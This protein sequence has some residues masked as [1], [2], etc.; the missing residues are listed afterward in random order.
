MRLAWM[1]LL[2]SATA[3][4]ERVV[5]QRGETLEHVAA[6]HGCTTEAVEHAN[7]VDTSLVKFG[8]VVEVPNCGRITTRAR[9][10]ERV[11][12]DDDDDDAKAKHALAVIDG[13]AWVPPP[14]VSPAEAG[15]APWAGS[16]ANASKLEAGDGYIVKRPARSFGTKHLLDHLRG[17]IAEVRAL[18]PNVPTLAIGDISAEYGGKISDHR[19]HQS[20]LDVDVGFYFT[21]G[22]VKTFA[23]AGSTFDLEAN[24]A[25]LAAFT[26]IAALDDGVQMIFLDYDLQHRLYDFA[27]RRGTPDSALEY[28]FQYPRGR[29]EL[30]GLVRHWPGHGNHFHVRFKP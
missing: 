5:V 6:A 12:D 9:T 28:I 20:G 23:D 21:N 29:D 7:H 1:L 15:G 10:R 16:L 2:V 17:A 18:Y 22:A 25:L 26:R 3:S 13:A 11:P 27:K 24:W 4:A 19:S 8:T 14:V 30:S